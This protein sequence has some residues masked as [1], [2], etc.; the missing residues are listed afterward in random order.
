MPAFTPN[1]NF[2]LPG[3]GSLGL[4][5]ENEAADIDKINQN[6]IDLDEWTGE[7]DDYM[8]NPQLS[9]HVGENS[10][11]RAYFGTGDEG[12]G[13]GSTYIGLAPDSDSGIDRALWVNYNG[14]EI[15]RLFKDGHMWNKFQAWAEA[16]GTVSK[17]TIGPNATINVTVN[18]PSGRFSKAPIVIATGWGD[19]RDVTV[20]VDSITTS[21][22]I[23]RIG[24]SGS[25]SRT[26]GA[27]WYASQATD[28]AAAG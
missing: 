13:T 23:I 14:T 19:A 18:F 7:V 20:H 21:K 25:F 24:N 17:R 2:Y 5:G 15:F 4:G 10:S 8:E 22:V 16:R 9:K 11:G 6:M 27:Q 28:G 12:T 26:L 1:R 3:G